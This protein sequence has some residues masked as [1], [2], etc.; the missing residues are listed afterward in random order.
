M[1]HIMFG[2]DYPY[3]DMGEAFAFLNGL[4]L[5]GEEEAALYEGNAA[6]LGLR[7]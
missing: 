4:G 1:D 6:R 5:S 7:F 2:T 3:E